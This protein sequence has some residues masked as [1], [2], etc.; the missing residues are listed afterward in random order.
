MIIARLRDRRSQAYCS[1]SSFLAAFH[2]VS[3]VAEGMDR[4]QFDGRDAEAAQMVNHALGGEAA[5]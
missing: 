5:E 4:Q 1:P 3:V 2:Q